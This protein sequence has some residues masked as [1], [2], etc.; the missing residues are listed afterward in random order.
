MKTCGLTNLKSIRS[1]VAYGNDVSGLFGRAINQCIPARVLLPDG[2]HMRHTKR[3]IS[4]FF[5]IFEP[6]ES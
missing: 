2:S 6:L 5:L 4:L 3:K 1:V